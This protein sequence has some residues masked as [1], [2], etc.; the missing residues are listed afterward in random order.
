MIASIKR[1]K[2][3][4]KTVSELVHEFYEQKPVKRYLY[5]I[6]KGGWVKDLIEKIADVTAEELPEILE[7]V[8]AIFYLLTH[9]VVVIIKIT[10]FPFFI[11]NDY[12]RIKKLA[13]EYIEKEWDIN[14]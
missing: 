12:F 9:I 10:V 4:G 3:T 7:G 11:T 8:K 14:T 1:S 13:K 2:K 6:F 5:F